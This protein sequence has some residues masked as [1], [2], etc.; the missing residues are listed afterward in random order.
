MFS[1][2]ARLLRLALPYWRGMLL[3]ALLGALTIAS[4]ISLMAASA[5]LIS[6]A[7]LQPSIAELGVAVVAVRFFG[8]ARGV[9]RYLERVVSHHTT[10]RLLARLRVAFYTA[11]EPLAP[12]RLW[13]Y[14]S[15]DLLA[16]AVADVDALQNMYLRV[17]AP[18]LTALL[19][20][21]A[22]TGLLLCFD[23][24]TALVALGFYVL[25]AAA[26]PALAWWRAHGAGRGLVAQR[27]RTQ[28]ALVDGI[29]GL[30]DILVYAPER[31]TEI[32]MEFQ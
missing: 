32:E 1:T 19:T 10:F 4:S 22:L 2:L 8:L 5:W 26:L 15:G 6:K 11:L 17:I 16:R 24:V 31:L 3:A 14:H 13:Q 27:A 12:A 30:A 7:A 29:Q 23:T 9:L 25:G 21:L 28:A 18:P 20:A